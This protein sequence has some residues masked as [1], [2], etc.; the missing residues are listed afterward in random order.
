M[1]T[2]RCSMLVL[3]ALVSFAWAAPPM[4][5]KQPVTDTYHGT[6]VTDDYRWLED[7]ASKDVKD[8]SAAQNTHA[9]AYLDKLP[10]VKSLREQ[11]TKILTAK[12]IT[13]YNLNWRGG[14][15][16]AMERQPP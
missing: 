9:R 10:G 12:T 5:K 11:L 3:F 14:Q 7:G 6:I 15:L 8:W 1:S 4:A 16:F 2:T 13:H